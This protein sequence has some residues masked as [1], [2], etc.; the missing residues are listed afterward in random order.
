[1]RAAP[2]LF[3]SPRALCAGLRLLLVCLLAAA[4]LQSCKRKS[5]PRSVE[6]RADTHAT[7]E[8]EVEQDGDAERAP[9]PTAT[10]FMRRIMAAWYRVPDNSLAKRR[11]APHELTAA[12]NRLPIGTRVRVTNPEN[13]R[14]VIVRITDRGIHDRRVKLDLCKEAADELGVAAKGLARVRMQVL[15]DEADSS[16]VGSSG[17]RN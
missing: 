1:M 12:H 10:P 13:G 17:A 7:A 2:D 15:R 9:E 4:P 11:A 8:Q 16:D 14:S 6:N 5:V 3:L